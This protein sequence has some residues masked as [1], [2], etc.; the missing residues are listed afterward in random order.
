MS[1]RALAELTIVTSCTDNYSPYLAEWAQSIA[2]GT[3]LPGR[4]VIVEN[5]LLA[6]S[7]YAEGA[8]LRLVE[9][10][11]PAHVVAIPR[12]DFGSARNAAVAK[13][14]TEWVMHLDADDMLM[15]HALEDV[16]ALMPEADVVALGYERTGDLRAGPA[17]R[18]RIYSSTAGAQALEAMAPASGVSPFRRSFWE[19]SPY[20]TDMEGGWDTALWI[21]FAHLGARFRATKRPGF[22]Y[23]QHAD[24]IF[25]TR[26]LD[27]RKSAMVGMKLRSLRAQHEGVSVLIPWRPDRGPRDAALSWLRRW[28]AARYPSWEVVLGEQAC[29]GCEWNKGEAVNAALA[30]ARGAVLVIADADCVPAAGALEQAVALVLAGVPWVVPHT[31][32][33]RLDEPTTKRVLASDPAGEVD[34]VGGVVRDPYEGFAGGGVVVVER[35]KFD[36]VGAYPTQF[37]GWGAEDEALALVLDTL[38]GV[39]TRLATPLWHL[40]HPQGVRT[41]H[42]RYRDNRVL[43]NRLA[44]VAPDPDAL[45][46]VLHGRAPG[47]LAGRKVR[48]VAL[49]EFPLGGRVLKAGENFDAS[50]EDARR[51]AMRKD[52][53]A[54]PVGP[55]AMAALRQHSRRQT[56]E[57]RAEQQRR[58]S[59][60]QSFEDRRLAAA[61][62]RTKRKGG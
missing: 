25:N 23:R 36:A 9:A 60:Q 18:R 44:A 14:A 31:M 10:G 57:I 43:F 55:A 42:P 24:S 7:T 30:K 56:L 40:W 33:H 37:F 61:G 2:A 3:V 35:A 11:I 13:A 62:I 27:E 50:V 17:N 32:V 52:K 12:T 58:N 4:C 26:R 59:E 15:Q 39:H 22:W 53:V 54:A 16:R 1:G 45:W 47:A 19:R 48:M 29:G 34:Y 8:M 49:K 28:Y 5:G 51:F 38:L 21:G 6:P 46:A 41:K 20:R